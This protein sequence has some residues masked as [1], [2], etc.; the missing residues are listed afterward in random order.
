MEECGGIG[1]TEM[2]DLA[3]PYLYAALVGKQTWVMVNQK[4]YFLSLFKKKISPHSNL[5]THFIKNN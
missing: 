5:V 2:F 1:S 3:G 4:S